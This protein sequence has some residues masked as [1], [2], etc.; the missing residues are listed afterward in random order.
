MGM[1]IKLY[2]QKQACSRLAYGLYKL[3]NS[4]LEHAGFIILAF[5]AA[6]SEAK[7]LNNF[8]KVIQ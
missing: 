1:L 3:P 4:E 7:G 8:P 2:L 5:E 6:E